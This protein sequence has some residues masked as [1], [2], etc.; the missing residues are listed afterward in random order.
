MSELVFRFK[1]RKSYP[2]AYYQ[3]AIGQAAL[4]TL[5]FWFKSGNGGHVH[6]WVLAPFI[7]MSI[8]VCM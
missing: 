3:T 7:Q 5:V 8:A 2:Q 1:S 4:G 6:M